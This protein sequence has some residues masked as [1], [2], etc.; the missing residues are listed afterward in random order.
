MAVISISKIQVRRGLQ[1]NLPQLASAEMGWSIDQRRLFIGNGSIAEGAPAIGNTEVLTSNS[2][3]LT[4]INSYTFRGVESTYT[5]RT[6]ASR[7]TPI[8]R[9]LQNKIDELIISSRD[10]GTIG[11]GVADDT[12][13]LQRAIDQIFP[14]DYFV[15]VGVRRKLNIPAGTYKITAP[16]TIPPYASIHGDGTLATIIRQTNAV[17]DSTVKLRDSKGQVDAAIGTNGAATPFQIDI[18]TLSFENTTNNN[19]LI[20]DS[21]NNVSFH[22]VSFLGN[23]PIPATTGTGTAAIKLI[24]TVSQSTRMTFTECTFSQVT[25]AW[26]IQGNVVNVFADSNSRIDTV[27][28]GIVLSAVSGISPTNIRYTNSIFS[29]IASHAVLTSDN[30]TFTS[31]FNRIAAAVGQGN[32]VVVNSG[33]ATAPTMSF[34]NAH[35]YSIGDYFTRTAANVGLFPLIE[36]T[37]TTRSGFT[38]QSS[39]GS[40]Q[41]STGFTDIL[42]NNISIAANTAITL[43]SLSTSFID[44]SITRS[45]SLRVGTVKVTQN[46]GAAVFVDDYSENA[47]TGV[48]LGVA[49]FGN[50]AIITYTTTSTGTGAIF[51]YNIRSFI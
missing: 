43:T 24:S 11:D 41:A 44:Y 47:S 22:Q 46:G 35:S 32:G 25:Y 37:G 26:L 19:I 14:I 51:K 23:Q 1:E 9:T 39:S 17:A 2:D 40:L 49:G 27:Y 6:G 5:S 12:I 21:F 33:V 42:T 20:A 15:T 38:M 28:Q 3:I 18:S 48:V 30:S 4:A 13:A 7:T 31:S 50:S 10:F 8:T 34:S 36:I 45:T 29:L 16:L